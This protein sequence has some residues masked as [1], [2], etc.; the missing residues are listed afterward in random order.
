[1]KKIGDGWDAVQRGS[2]VFVKGTKKYP[3]F[4]GRT[5]TL[6]EGSY[7]IEGFYAD[8]VK[9][10]KDSVDYVIPSICLKDFYTSAK[11]RSQRPHQR[12]FRKTGTTF[13]AG[14]GEPK[15]KLNFPANDGPRMSPWGPVQNSAHLGMGIYSV[16]TAGHGGIKVPVDLNN[17]IPEYMRNSDGWY[18]EDGEWAIPILVFKELESSKTNYTAALETLRNWYPAKYERFTGLNVK[19]GE[20]IIRDDEIHRATNKDNYLALTAWGDWHE[21]VPKGMVAVFAGRGGRLS[22]GKYP[23][24][25]AYFLVPEKEYGSRRHSFVIDEK[26]H[27]RIA[28]EDG[29]TKRVA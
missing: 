8:A 6:K 10:Q 12:T 5:H 21:N 27:K 17:R 4:G 25:T 7:L 18:E 14:R 2:N 26:K 19:P 16:S 29:K 11:G 28:W 3:T 22:D 15:E 1:M 9:L 20:S 23:A 13:K 24:D